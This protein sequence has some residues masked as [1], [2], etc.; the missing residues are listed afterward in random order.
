M[1]ERNKDK[2]KGLKQIIPEL[3]MQ[4]FFSLNYEGNIKLD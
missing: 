3:Y 4:L 1:Q 2:L